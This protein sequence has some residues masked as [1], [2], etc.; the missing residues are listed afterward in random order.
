MGRGCRRCLVAEAD[1]GVV[2]LADILI[3]VLPVIVVPRI[4]PAHARV[5]G[6]DGAR[7]V[8]RKPA[9]RLTV[10]L[11]AV[12][13]DKWAYREPVRRFVQR[14]SDRIVFVRF[15]FGFSLSKQATKHG[16]AAPIV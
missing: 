10:F 14:G 11:H 8:L 15:K 7:V 9:V 1:A 12:V 2:R 4:V 6:R 16:R 3:V 13:Y 5:A